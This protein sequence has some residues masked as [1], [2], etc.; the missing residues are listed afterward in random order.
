VN[1][2]VISWIFLEV[3][4]L[5]EIKGDNPFKIRSYRQAARLLA[6]LDKDISIYWA[7]GRL[8]ELPGI[9]SALADKISELLN[10]GHLSYLKKLRE[11]VP[12]QFRQLL[13]IPGV[14]PRTVYTIH[15]HLGVN[16]IEE[17]KAAVSD[18]KLRDLP[19]LGT[20]SELAIKHALTQ[21]DSECLGL[22]LGDAATIVSELVEAMGQL[23]L[24]QSI[25]VAGE[26]R[27]REE[28]INEAQLVAAASPE[29]ISDI[30]A[31]FSSAPYVRKIIDTSSTSI[32]ALLGI[33]LEVELVVVQPNEFPTSLCYFTG[34]PKYWESLS[35]WAKERGFK[36]SPTGLFYRGQPMALVTEEDLYRKL[37]LEFIIPEQRFDHQ[38]ILAAAGGTLPKVIE[39]EHI[40]GDLHLH[41]SYSDGRESVS[42]LAQAVV[43][44]G[45]EYIAITDHSQSLK[46]ARGLDAARLRA[47]A[48]EID[49]VRK[50]FPELTIL[51]GIEVDI[52]RDGRLDFGNDVLSQLDLVIASVHSGFKQD[53]ETMTGRIMS[54][55]RNPYVDILGH[56]SGRLLGRRPGYRVDL[57]AVIKEAKLQ[58]K[59]LEINSSPER[60]D[61]SAKWAAKAKKMGV[62]IVINSDAHDVRRLADIEYGVS[63]ARRAGLE[64]DDIINTWPVARLKEFLKNRGTSTRG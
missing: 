4:D 28:F 14:G 49:H 51:A 21:L 18:R 20:K 43:T 23:P 36:L 33:G 50:K 24:V 26:I 6:N 59:V 46:I 16:T 1:N 53:K 13:T 35:H 12:A 11:E 8:T 27:R 57:D 55:L 25:S 63:V 52:L 3:A 41:T 42:S 44:R 64:I 54:A 48:Q 56:P 40:R 31:T 32:T 60:L 39:P 22:P 61:L 34:P 62:K 10:T 58:G 19:G 47:Q 9:G 5:L 7:D 45:Y 30:L 37:G 2:L 29:N 17:L 15:K 38:S